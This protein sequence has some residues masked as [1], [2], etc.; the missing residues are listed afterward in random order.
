[1]PHIN[2]FNFFN[3][4]KYENKNVGMQ[5]YARGFIEERTRRGQLKIIL[6]P[7]MWK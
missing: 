4:W 2:N 5:F 3:R 1:M 7:I 6:I